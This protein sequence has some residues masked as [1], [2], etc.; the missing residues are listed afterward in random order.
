MP[1]SQ[2]KDKEHRP[3]DTDWSANFLPAMVHRKIGRAEVRQH[4]EAQNALDK[5]RKKLEAI[6]V[7]DKDHPESWPDVA[8]RA[9]KAGKHVYVGNL[10]ELVTQKHSELSDGDPLKKYKGRIVYR[11]DDIRDEFFDH[12]LFGD[13]ASA[14]SSMAASKACD[15][16][17]APP[18]NATQLSD[19]DSAYIQNISGGG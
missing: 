9:R 7:W 3:K 12:A 2:R 18:G 13:V 5:E 4:P 6:P 8:R 17:G 10:M 14:P 19:A 15:A 16:W 11:G 1:V